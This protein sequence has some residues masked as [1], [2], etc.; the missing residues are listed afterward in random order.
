MGLVVID[1]FVPDSWTIAGV[2]VIFLIESTL[3]FGALV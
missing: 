2:E 3:G 1:I